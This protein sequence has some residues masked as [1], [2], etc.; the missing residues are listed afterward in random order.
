MKLR[1]ATCQVGSKKSWTNLEGSQNSYN[2]LITLVRGSWT[3]LNS[4][5]CMSH[6][7]FLKPKIKFPI[8][9]MWVIIIFCIALSL[10]T[11]FNVLVESLHEDFREDPR[12][13]THI[14]S[15]LTRKLAT[16]TLIN[17]FRAKF[18]PTLIELFSVAWH[19]PWDSVCT[20]VKSS[21]QR[22]KVEASTVDHVHLTTH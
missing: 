12:S 21:C 11:I 13:W 20:Y 10:Q 2:T 3:T 9:L 18:P 14:K 8:K 6:N 5:I 22:S 19:L 16:P 15:T 1:R 7:N 4:P 17:S